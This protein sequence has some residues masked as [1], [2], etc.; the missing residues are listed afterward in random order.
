MKIRIEELGKLRKLTLDKIAEGIGISR[1]YLYALMSGTGGKRF[2][3][4][5]LNGLL[6]VFDCSVH[7]LFEDDIARK[8]VL[9]RDNSAI[10]GIPFKEHLMMD[11]IKKF[12]EL[13]HDK[14]EILEEFTPENL[15]KILTAAYWSGHEEEEELSKRT[16]IS[17]AFLKNQLRL[18]RGG[19]Q[20]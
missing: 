12:M 8:P 18:Y 4:D 3:T 11:V 19:L 16:E 17:K 1:S 15:A 10:E 14:P 9:V 13:L 7:D 5:H 20:Q 6:K 2:N